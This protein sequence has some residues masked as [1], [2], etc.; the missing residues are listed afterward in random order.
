MEIA[1]WMSEE[2]KEVFGRSSDGEDGDLFQADVD[3]E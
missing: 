1:I 3:E 2:E